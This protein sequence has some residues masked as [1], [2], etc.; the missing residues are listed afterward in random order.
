[1]TLA[2]AFPADFYGVVE[3]PFHRLLG[4]RFTRPDPR[5]PAVIRIPARESDD[6]ETER[7]SPAVV[8]AAAEI[9]AAIAATDAIWPHVADTELRPVLLTTAV[10]LE[11]LRPAFGEVYAH[12]RFLGD[13]RTTFEKLKCS[14]KARCAVE[15]DL[16]DTGIDRSAQASVDLYLRLMSA[17]LWQS[18]SAA[19]D[20]SATPRQPAA[21]G[22]R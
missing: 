12:T 7:R 16:H 13:S 5:G 19:R 3:V 17:E 11:I 1:L 2:P 14:R 18:M 4:V 22:A 15:V 6:P 9:G 21:E 8:F 10:R 20:A